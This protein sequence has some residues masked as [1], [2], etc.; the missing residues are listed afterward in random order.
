[1]RGLPSYIRPQMRTRGFQNR[2]R[3]NGLL[4][5]ALMLLALLV[6]SATSAPAVAQFGCI[7]DSVQ[8]VQLPA[9]DTA[10]AA[11]VEQSDGKQVPKKASHCAFC[12]CSQICSAKPAA[13]AAAPLVYSDAVYHRLLARPL[14]ATARD[15]PERPP[16][17]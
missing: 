10:T 3:N 6:I 14:P 9:S 17:T 16:R 11:E 2:L 1:M 13:R 8:Q 7:E 4:R 15:G 5:A 12:D